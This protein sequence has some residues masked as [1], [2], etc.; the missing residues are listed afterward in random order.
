MSP[1]G[2]IRRGLLLRSR[3]H[4]KVIRARLD[5]GISHDSETSIAKLGTSCFSPHVSGHHGFVL[6]Q[7]IAPAFE[8]WPTGLT[9]CVSQTCTMATILKDFVAQL[10][11]VGKAVTI[12]LI[13]RDP[14]KHVDRRV[15][16]VEGGF[17]TFSNLYWRREPDSL[18]GS[19][20]E[21]SYRGFKHWVHERAGSS[22]AVN[23][24]KRSI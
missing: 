23:N 6:C 22:A 7:D 2:M 18:E 9:T 14:I 13:D 5:T 11:F 16:I 19:D 12:F 10:S 3:D 15:G 8:I 21:D 20:R 4:R 17:S 24:V 1:Q